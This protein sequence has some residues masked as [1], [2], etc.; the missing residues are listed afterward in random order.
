LPCLYV[1]RNT[2]SY[3]PALFALPLMTGHHRWYYPPFIV[4]V[5]PRQ[6]LPPR[7][8][9]IAAYSF[10]CLPPACQRI[11]VF[12]AAFSPPFFYHTPLYKMPRLFQ[13]YVIYQLF[14]VR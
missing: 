12:T 2:I 3:L 14:R 7:A 4:T 8:H 5:L 10:S 1:Y 11:F 6:R 13:H 9:A